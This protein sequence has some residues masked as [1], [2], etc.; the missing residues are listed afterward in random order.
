MASSRARGNVV[1]LDQIDIATDPRWGAKG[2]GVTDDLVALQAFIDHLISTG[3]MGIIP[4][5]DYAYDGELTADTSTAAGAQKGLRLIG[6]F[7]HTIMR[8][9]DA[10]LPC[11]VRTGRN[12]SIDGIA[13]RHNTMPT[14]LDTR[15]TGYE[16]KGLF[17]QF[18]DGW[19]KFHKVYTA[20]QPAA[21]GT[22][23]FF[24]GHM[25]HVVVHQYATSAL[26]CDATAGGNTPYTIDSCYTSNMNDD[27]V[28]RNTTTSPVI[29]IS[30]SDGPIFGHLHIE[31]V[32]AATALFVGSDVDGAK[33]GTL[34]IENFEASGVGQLLDVSGNSV[35]KRYSGLVIDHMQFL[36]CLF[37]N[38]TMGSNTFGIAKLGAGAQLTIHH[39][40]ERNNTMDI[41]DF[42]V[43]RANT[44]DNA[45][46]IETAMW[47][48]SG[49]VI[50]ALGAPYTTI[51]KTADTDQDTFSSLPSLLRRWLGLEYFRISDNNLV[52]EHWTA[53]DA[54]PSAGTW[55]A[56]SKRY[57]TVPRAGG[58]LG[59]VCL[60]AGTPGTWAK[61]GAVGS[62]GV[63]DTSGSSVTAPADANE[64]T[65]ATVAIPAGIMGTNGMLRI[66]A[67]FTVTNSGNNKTLR[68]KY[69]GT[70][71]STLVVTAVATVRMVCEIFNRAAANSQVSFPNGGIGTTASA[72]VTA[73]IDSATAQDV[74]ITG[75]K[76]T[77]GETIRMESYNVE[78]IAP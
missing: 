20:F 32:K 37:V 4:P 2:D 72:I 65:L 42:R 13:W 44:G 22:N 38:A 52:Y 25:A 74:T 35:S 46:T 31:N 30:S 70:A 29:N 58:N 27:G 34:H 10:N 71:F 64:N 19:A 18:N 3:R 51:I 69:G 14:T 68:L 41:T 11:L 40:S 28:T 24:A 53:T 9:M 73:A 5:G 67:V 33:I 56:G 7:E 6:C 57:L 1:K 26:V 77:A 54:D 75:Q 48:N 21:A 43:V 61:M 59:R 39:L 62:A 78:V 50:T 60:A 12:Q 49:T 23:A 76:A 16:F 8:Q 45:P 47:V 63:V 66:T 55:T 17:S 36:S 15:G